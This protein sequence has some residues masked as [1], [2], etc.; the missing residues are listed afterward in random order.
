[1]GNLPVNCE[2]VSNGT[3]R[4]T[5]PRP[6]K[7]EIGGSNPPRPTKRPPPSQFFS[8]RNLPAL[9]TTYPLPRIIG[10]GSRLPSPPEM[11]ELDPFWL[12]SDMSVTGDHAGWVRLPRR[13]PAA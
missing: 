3:K 10:S 8:P 6:L 7:A 2:N 11:V 9:D 12:K 13:F 5:K 1:M 4:Y